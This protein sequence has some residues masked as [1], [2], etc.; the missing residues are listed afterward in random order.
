MGDPAAIKVERAQAKKRFTSGLRKLNSSLQLGADIDKI[1]KEGNDLEECYGKLCD[2]HSDYEEVSNT[3]DSEYLKTVTDEFNTTMKSYYNALKQEREIKTRREN[4]PLITSVERG[5]KSVESSIEILDKVDISNFDLHTVIV[6]KESLEKNMLEMFNNMKKV[7]I[8]LDTKELEGRAD[9]LATRANS[10]LRKCEIMVRK[11]TVSLD[12]RSDVADP[13]SNPT[14]KLHVSI[15]QP[16]QANAPE[17][18]PSSK[19]TVVNTDITDTSV[20]QCSSPVSSVQ[21]P[22]HFQ[23]Q[24]MAHSVGTIQTKK[25]SLPIFSG[26]REDWPEFKCVWRTLAEAQFGNR[27]QLAMELKK[28]CKGKA[29]EKVQHIYATSEEAYMSIWQRLSDEY[30]DPGLAVQSAIGRLLSLKAISDRDYHAIVKFADIAEGV[31]SQLKELGQLDAIHMVDVDRLSQLLPAEVNMN[32]LRKYRE[33]STDKKLKPFADFV[34]FLRNERSVVARLS[35][36]NRKPQRPD[37]TDSR[38][39]GTHSTQSINK[40]ETSK[41]NN[42]NKAACIFHPESQHTT[43]K[44]RTFLKLSLN[45]K[46]R[47]LK[48]QRRCF[49]C[50]E[51]HH[52]TEC[53]KPPCKKCGKFHH[54]LLCS[55]HEGKDKREREPEKEPQQVKDEEDTDPK[56]Y[57]ETGLVDKGCK[58]LFPITEVQVHKTDKSVTVFLDAGSNA[59]YVTERCADRLNLDKVEKVTLEVAVVG[60]DIRKYKSTIYNIPL[61]TK[62]G[63]VVEIKAYSLES[64]TGPL[65]ELNSSLIKKLFPRCNHDVLQRKSKVVDVLVGTDYFGL[66]PKKELAKAGNNLSIM[67]GQLGSCIVGTHPELKEH[68]LRSDKMPKELHGSYARTHHA[69]VIHPAFNPPVTFFKGEDL[70]T[71][72]NPKCGG[73][74]CGKCPIP[75]HTLSFREEQE[76]GEIRDNLEY[77]PEEKC[78]VTSYPWIVNPKVLPDNEHIAKAVL[79]KTEKTLIKDK[80]WADSY[81]EQ[82]NDMMERGAARALPPEEKDNWEGPKFYI[83]HLAVK[84]PKSKSTPVRIVFNSSHSYQGMSLNSCLAKGPDSFANS[85]IGILLRWR[86]NHAVLV[87]DIR[88]MFHS[89]RLKLLEQHCHRFLWRNLE[90]DKEPETYVITKVNM[91]DRPASAIATEAMFLTADRFEETFPQAAEF[92]HRSAYV[93]D[94]I[95]STDSLEQAKELAQAVTTL[96]QQGGFTLKGWK[97]SGKQETREEPTA[98]LGVKW[99]PEEDCIQFQAILNFSPKKHGAHTQPNLVASDP[100]PDVL[101]RRNVLKQVMSIYDPLGLLSPFTLKAKILLRKTWEIKLGWDDC[102]PPELHQDWCKFFAELFQVNDL[103][104]QRCLKPKNA[105]GLPWL[106]ILSDGSTQAYGCAAYA[107]WECNDGT[108]KMRLI[109]A[110]SR[111][112]PLS[113]VSI[114]RMELNGA[115]LSKRCRCVIEKEMQIK[116]SR[117][118]HLVDSSTVLNQLHRLSSRFQVYEGVRIGEIQSATNGDMSE[119]GWI[120][121]SENTADW[122]TRGK[123]PK[124]LD[125]ESEWVNGPSMLHEPAESWN[126]HFGPTSNEPVPGEK[127]A[128]AEQTHATDALHNGELINLSR[129]GSFQKTVRVTARVMNIA[130]LKSFS[131]GNQKHMTVEAYRKAE[132]Y[133]ISDAQKATDFKSKSLKTLNPS[134]N[135]D[136]L[137]VVGATR[138]VNVNP[139]GIRADLPIFIPKGHPLAELAMKD[140][141]CKGHRGR[142]ATVSLFRNRFWTPSAGR[143]GKKVKDKCQMCK[144][145]DGKPMN[146]IMGRLPPERTKP[147]PPF[148][149]SMVDIFGPYQI[150]GEVQK[151]TS[152]K[153]WGVIFTDLTSRAVHIEGMFGYDASSF[154]LALVRFVGIRGWPSKMYSDPGSQLTAAEKELNQAAAREGVNHGMDWI[155]GPADSPWHQGAVEALVKTAKRAINFAVHDQR[156]SAPE[157]LSVCAAAADTINSRP[158]GLLPALDNDINILTPNCLLLGR[159]SSDN[160]GGWLQGND[161]LKTRFDLVSSINNHFW[162]KWV[163]L[164]APSLVHQTKWFDV[165]PDLQV[166][167]VVIVLDSNSLRNEYKLALVA[168]VHPG[169]DG[170]VRSATVTYKRFKVGESV[171]HYK[172]ATDTA[173]RRGVQRL[174]RLVNI[175]D[176][177][178]KRA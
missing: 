145:R 46:Y 126:V 138:L 93:D 7:S 53:K 56:K 72:V 43:D 97:F 120:P 150:R 23:A 96:L 9:A 54:S 159:A 156:L 64:I 151:R 165:K 176:F 162:K 121:G 39:A 104:I 117:V 111:I 158:I 112:A 67:E 141:H 78:W 65:S 22:S 17:F 89:V 51:R 147:A 170:K 52:R 13:E 109:M 35:E 61:V 74:K 90:Q 19:V 44:C 106:I 85:S 142:D 62:S 27:L 32:W 107:R 166:G 58:A 4:A 87:G 11:A 55:S 57:V 100:L 68:T 177:E 47:E 59:S 152:G 21:N 66:H 31:H 69:S 95:G 140:A 24:S 173:I 105:A 157:F 82:M 5:F 94:L 26:R 118:L 167:D 168:D 1:S 127:K 83:N 113:I 135:K 119:W 155:I 175:N 178:S 2:L 25:P 40:F 131:G 123:S 103:R 108:I 92:I 164:F 10:V 116:F 139:M 42:V 129:F 169:R 60:G 101:T 70:A 86:E 12:R 91:G 8:S 99:D 6:D 115:V 28:C 49:G 38:K 171:K 174:I 29:A 143:L 45:Q 16:L 79:V 80:D 63:K 88:K 134:Q 137:W 149:H 71:E 30:D 98:V 20:L 130:K 146:Q 14:G 84:N 154:L 122:L 76:L 18:T 133:L 160:P 136:G 163:E 128:Y 124:E 114:P 144:L 15:N 41:Q 132:Q 81:C 125:N 48:D 33:L 110:K 148:N 3:D 37:K 75:G 153:A 36:W 50:F 34:E 102:L 172:G 161:S 77:N 73:C